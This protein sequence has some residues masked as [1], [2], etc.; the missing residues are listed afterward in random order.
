MRSASRAALRDARDRL[1]AAVTDRAAA[2]ALSEDLFAVTGLLD[3]EP[4]LRRALTDASSAP[5]ARTGL[6][7]GLLGGRVSR[8]TLELAAGM[9]AERWS[10]PGDLP[11]ATEQL[12]VFAAAAAADAEGQLDD[13]EDELF[14]FGRIAAGNAE[15][16]VALS[17]RRLPDDAKR[18]L[19]E[20]LLAGKVSPSALRLII[21]AALAPRERGLEAS[22]ALYAELAAAWRNRLIAVVRVATDLTASQ[23]ERLAAALSALYGD[24]VHL[25]VILDPHVIGGLSVQIGD[26]FIDGTLS[27]RLAALR[28]KL[29]A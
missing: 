17:G 11:D 4:G 9:V 6:V 13:L 14:R 2:T 12:A 15:L 22:L 5:E 3:R 24:S 8:A 1:T 20:T 10:V 7:R 26:E 28:Q 21:Q 25:N 18:G 29:A 23:H 27:S 16:H 19:L